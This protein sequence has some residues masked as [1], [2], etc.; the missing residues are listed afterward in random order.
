MSIDLMPPAGDQPTGYRGK[1]EEPVKEASEHERAA[2]ND[3][4]SR[5]SV[6]TATTCTARPAP[7]GGANRRARGARSARGAGGGRGH[8]AGGPRPV[9]TTR[10]TNSGGNASLDLAVGDAYGIGINALAIVLFLRHET[11]SFAV[12]R[13][14]SP[15]YVSAT[16]KVMA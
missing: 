10:T 3:P 6:H 15:P 4:S 12:A 8:A 13:G 16:C 7:P 5:A 14:L 2:T 11:G 9:P 1:G